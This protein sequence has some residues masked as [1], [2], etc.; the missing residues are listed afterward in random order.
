MFYHDDDNEYHS[1]DMDERDYDIPEYIL[2]ENEIDRKLE[3]I[4]KFKKDIQ[5]EI[6]FIGV[7]NISNSYILETIENLNLYNRK[8]NY[9]LTNYQIELFNDL[10]L[11][12]FNYTESINTY[13]KIVTIM[14][15]KIYV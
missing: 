10:F 8:S 2:Y 12:L 14:F 4:N 13:E 6:D 1:D 9:I 11:A 5:N 3:I 15:S 7:K